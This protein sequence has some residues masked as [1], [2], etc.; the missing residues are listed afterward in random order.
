MTEHS[1]SASPKRR[2]GRPVA[3]AL[4]LACGLALVALVILLPRGPQPL[5]YVVVRGD[6]LGRIAAQHGV[7]V[8]ELRAWNGIEGDLIEVG[9]VLHIH[10]G[11]AP[12]APSRGGSSPAR[13]APAEAA[14]ARSL[15]PA[16]PCLPPPDPAML[17]AGDEPGFLA[18]QG[19]NRAQIEGAMQA[20]V[21][22]LFAC[23]PEDARPSGVMELELEV[24]CSGRV[25]AVRILDG[26]GLPESL[27]GCV[28]DRLGYAAFP[29]HD[30]PDGYTFHYPL[31]FSW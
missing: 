26:D 28:V 7:S 21:P 29:A 30:M 3:V 24:A 11:Q 9:E 10:G 5:E 2:S 1:P 13:R 23:V 8:D 6:T 12:V 25:A 17:E 4:G 19:L 20:A 22:G 27:V 18:S 31:R 15:P 14:A 16:K